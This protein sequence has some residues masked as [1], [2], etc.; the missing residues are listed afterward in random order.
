V[1]WGKLTQATNNLALLPDLSG[2]VIESDGVLFDGAGFFVRPKHV[3]NA[4]DMATDF[5]WGAVNNCISGGGGV[6]ADCP[7][8]L[9]GNGVRYDTPTWYGFSA[10]AGEYENMEWD[11]AIKY[12]AD[13]NSFKVSAAY[14]FAENTDEGCHGTGAGITCG[15]GA[16]AGGGGAPFQGFRKDVISNQVGASIMH[17]PSGLWI[18]G[19]WEDE[20]NQGSR[21][22]TDTESL[23]SEQ[24]RN[25]KANDNNFWFL[26][27]GIKRTWTPL[28]ATVIWGEG[29]QAQDMFAG[30]CPSGASQVP[31]NSSNGTPFGANCDTA[32]NTGVFGELT[33]PHH[34]GFNTSAGQ[35]NQQAVNIN[36]STV[37]RFGA[38]IVQEIDAA[39]MHVFFRWQHLD[40][41]LNV[42]CDQEAGC[43][44][45]QSQTVK[46]GQHFTPSYDGLDIFQIGGVI[47]F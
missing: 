19:M 42:T 10:S 29:G 46:F 35:G 6:A 17:V 12:A 28:G 25:S 33:D 9:D 30:L 40:L 37:N 2:T 24:I 36:N 1:N 3:I 4:N 20:E 18:Y 13:W 14:G 32:I 15:G 43:L 41:N 7:T 39:A 47:F 44:N 11:A 45:G 23:T 38:G 21:I 34:L 16:E 26:K 5:T 8:G 31:N 27:G 22:F